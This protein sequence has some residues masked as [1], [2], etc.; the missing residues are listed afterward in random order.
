MADGLPKV[1]IGS[2]GGLSD[3]R[4]E[5]GKSHLDGV[6]IR[7]IPRQEQEPVPLFFQQCLGLWG[8]MDGQIVKNDDIALR[9]DPFQRS[10]AFPS[11]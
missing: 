10:L 8:F 5:F 6:Q 3:Q 7:A 1:V 2:G 9:A 4:L 11:N